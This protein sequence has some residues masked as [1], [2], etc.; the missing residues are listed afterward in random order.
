MRLL[1]FIF[2]VFLGLHVNGCIS[3]NEL[4]FSKVAVVVYGQNELANKYARSAFTRVENLLLDNGIE[5]LDQQK[6]K[7]LKNVWKQLEDP[8][9]F[10]TAETFVENTEKY[11]LDGIVRV[12]LTAESYESW[13]KSHSATAIADVRFVDKEAKVDAFTSIPMGVP[14]KPP[15]DGLTKSAAVVNAV[16][17]AIDES[18]SK[19]GLEVFDYAKPRTMAFKLEEVT[20]P[21][22][23]TKSNRIEFKQSQFDQYIPKLTRRTERE[24]FTCHAVDPSAVL[25]VAGGYVKVSGFGK[26]TYSS[27]LHVVDLV[28]KKVILTFDTSLADRKHRWEK[29]DRKLHDCMFIHNWRFL[30]GL[31]GNHLSLWDTE[32]GVNMSEI[33]LEKGIKKGSRLDYV[34]DGTQDYIVILEKG[35]PIKYFMI[36]R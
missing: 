16:Q 10:V 29:G 1:P 18:I 6:V 23:A 26:R 32:K 19:L 7:E 17:R 14:G 24:S 5:V 3:A 35:N 11:T 22:S 9:F 30:A 28:D 25:G 15:S 34:T 21:L 33:H 8:G 4:K 36:T 27:R 2:F 12:Y 20:I 13:G 31:T